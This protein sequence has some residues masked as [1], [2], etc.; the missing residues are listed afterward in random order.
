MK[1]GFFTPVWPG[2]FTPNGIT[3]STLNLVNGVRALGHEAVVVADK[4]DA[5][6]VDATVVERQAAWSLLDKAA[7]RLRL[8]H[9]TLAKRAAAISRTVERVVAQEQV[10]VFY[11]EESFGHAAKV[12]AAL[13]A[14]VG[15]FLR[16]PYFLHKSIT[17]ASADP[18]MNRGRED[19]EG[20]AVRD[21]FAVLA[22]SR[23]VLDLALAHYDVKPPWTAVI[24]NPMETKAAVD[25]AAFAPAGALPMLFVGRF[26]TH[27]GADI[28]LGAFE[29][30][31]AQ[32]P[33]VRLTFVGPDVGVP[34]PENTASSM[35]IE[36]ALSRLSDDVRSRIDYRGPLPKKEIDALRTT[37]PIT[38]V[39]SRY[40]TF[41]NTVTEAMAAGQAVIASDTG[42]I[43][44]IISANKTGLLTPPADPDAL[45]AACLRLQQDPDLARRLGADAREHIKTAFA[46]ISVARVLV[47]FSEQIVS[48][49]KSRTNSSH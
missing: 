16:G 29:K 33:N 22:P 35:H 42:G 25:A 6:G 31:A 30:L 12:Q 13:N 3:T 2:A 40:E 15:V 8:T 38:L 9:P 49:Y 24:P 19:A 43:T 27:K 14:P 21:C 47:D 4:I 37:H 20:K 1:I 46:P 39:P 5:E 26:D 48:A 17:R 23:N 28:L 45:G 7:Y 32:A 41:G 36:T 44:E 10:D 11:M 18:V 34:D